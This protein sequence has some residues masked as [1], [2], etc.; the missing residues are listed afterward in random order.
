MTIKEWLETLP[1]GYKERALANANKKGI[2]LSE[3]AVSLHRAIVRACF[4]LKSVEG[5]DFWKGVYKYY[6]H[7]S[8][9]TPLPE[10]PKSN[11]L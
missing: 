10:L 7:L 5:F 6:Y 3:E 9:C 11:N 2:D 8:M 1:E 4:M